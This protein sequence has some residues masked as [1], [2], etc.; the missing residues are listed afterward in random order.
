[1]GLMRVLMMALAAVV[2]LAL[3]KRFMPS[4]RNKEDPTAADERLGRLIQDPECGVYVD[5]KEAIQRDVPGGELY[6]CSKKCADIYL[7]KARKEG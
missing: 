1:M 3:A 6:F 7:E 2:I 4:M 5:G